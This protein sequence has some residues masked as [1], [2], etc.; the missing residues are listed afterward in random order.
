MIHWDGH[1]KDVTVEAVDPMHL[2]DVDYFAE[3]VSRRVARGFLTRSVLY[4]LK[5]LNVSE[6]DARNGI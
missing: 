6:I 5:H 4:E 2:S 3:L 1:E